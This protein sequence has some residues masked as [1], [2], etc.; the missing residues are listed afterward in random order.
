MSGQ[1]FRGQCLQGKL[2]R[3]L[4]LNELEEIVWFEFWVNSLFLSGLQ[5]VY[6]WA[7]TRADEQSKPRAVPRASF[8]VGDVVAKSGVQ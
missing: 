2:C 6:V 7:V 5:S 4:A 3:E 1:P 8:M